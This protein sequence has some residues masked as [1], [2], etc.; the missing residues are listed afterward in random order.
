MNLRLEDLTVTQL[1]VD[2]K[3]GQAKERERIERMNG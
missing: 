2:H 3:P 1:T